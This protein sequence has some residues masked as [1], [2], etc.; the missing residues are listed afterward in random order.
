MKF[1]VLLPLVVVLLSAC[2][3]QGMYTF[4]QPWREDQCLRMQNID[5]KRECMNVSRT[6]YDTYNE[7]RSN[8]TAR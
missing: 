6:P 7:A 2:S 1:G 3:N 4:F 5:A 8:A